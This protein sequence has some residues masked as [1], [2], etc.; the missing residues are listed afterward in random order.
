[1][2][3]LYANRA[4]S[5]LAANI[6]NVATSLSVAAGHGAR[7]PTI[8][9]SDYFYATL[10][11][12]AGTVEVVKVTARSTDTFTI[13]RA[14]DG[15]SASAFNAGAGVELRLV[16]AMID[17]IKFDAV[18]NLTLLNMP[19]A[20]F[21]RSVK[22]ATTANITLSGAQTIDGVSIVAGDR[23]LVKNQ[24]TASQNGI[25]IA[26]AS[27]WTRA[28][29]ADTAD[30]IGAAI[31]N[32]DQGTANGGESWTTTFRTT[33]TVGTTAMPW[34]EVLYN[35]GTWGISTTGNAATATALATARTING[36]AFNG[37]ANITVADSTK[38][39][40][41]GGTLTGAITGIA[42]G[43]SNT[44]AFY[45]STTGGSYA[46]MNTRSGPY[47]T[48]A[49]HSGSSYA[50]G[51]TMEYEYTGLY[52]GRYSIGHLTTS[53]ANPG[54]LVIQHINSAGASQ[55]F[56]NFD[57]ANGNFT[58]TGNVTAYSDERLKSDWCFLPADFVERLAKV[59][60]GTYTR[61]DSGEH[62][63]GSSAQDWQQLLPE[64]VAVGADDAKTLS[65]AYGNAALVSAIELAKRV[66][67]QEARIAKLEALVASLTGV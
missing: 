27:T 12:N 58:A 6:T 60:S 23:V 46:S 7:F 49:N 57:G 26:S 15:T 66:V 33:D 25:Y 9:G 64:A 1:M 44:T 61:L 42:S 43:G 24:T 35:N 59:K 10:D 16:K 29:D 54:H 40:L 50:P 51:F 22:A 4:F 55:V 18:Q 14:Q 67:S 17:D 53:A 41:S 21:K 48:F 63:V 34:Y 19:S 36:V 37:T 56:W 8:T 28:T 39:P 13:V 62:Q 3:V 45:A 65:L 20:A 47:R 30:E 2:P 31:V 32:V 38:L 52:A 5:T 11:N